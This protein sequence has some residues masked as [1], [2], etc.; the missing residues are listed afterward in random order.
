[1][2]VLDTTASRSEEE[3]DGMNN[4]YLLNYRLKI[5]LCVDVNTFAQLLRDCCDWISKQ[6][7][8]EFGVQTYLIM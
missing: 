6:W 2:E 7:Q 1:M 4:Q 8:S 5:E 3:N